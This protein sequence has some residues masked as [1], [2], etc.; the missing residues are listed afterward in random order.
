MP[1]CDA[2]VQAVTAA[3]GD[4]GVYDLPIH[5]Q[6]QPS[7][8]MDQDRLAKWIQRLPK[9]VGI[10]A[11]SDPRAQRVLEA[12]RRTGV[13]VPDDVAV[14]GTGNDETTCELCDPPLSSVIA[15]HS[16]IGYESGAMLDHLMH[17]GT[18]PHC[19]PDWNRWAW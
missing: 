10:M 2:C 11:R 8:E 19:P 17:G 14:V 13:V 5:K 6:T 7:W 4:C 3:G 15:R 16:Q 1:T 9:P 18:A 12:C